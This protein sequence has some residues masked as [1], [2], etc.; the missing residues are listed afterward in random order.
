[1]C[2]SYRVMP[3][4]V[5]PNN[6]VGFLLLFSFSKCIRFPTL[7]KLK[8]F[9]L[10]VCKKRNELSAGQNLNVTKTSGGNYVVRNAGLLMQ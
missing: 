9:Q 3:L 5:E 4:A 10:S 1:M 7:H 2:G 8:A 6:V